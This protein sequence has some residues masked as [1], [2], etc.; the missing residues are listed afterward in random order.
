[1]SAL[2]KSHQLALPCLV[3]LSAGLMIS[4]C[5]G[6]PIP[7]VPQLHVSF[8]VASGGNS[9]KSMAVP[10]ESAGLLVAIVAN[11]SDSHQPQLFSGQQKVLAKVLGFDPISRLQF[12]Q[13]K[14]EISQP[15]SAWLPEVDGHANSHL[16]AQTLTG[17]VQC[18]TLGWTKLIGGKVLPL[19]LLRVAFD[20]EVPLPGTP[21]VTKGGGIVAIVF[22]ASATGKEAYAIPAEAVHR[23]RRD[24]CEGR[25]LIRGWLG[26]ALRAENQ[27]PQVVRVLPDSPAARAGTLPGDVL[28]HIGKRKISD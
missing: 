1:M 11:G 15:V 22:Q 26:L 25:P 21:L 14:N 3:G 28:T 16:T 20:G 8:Q 27:I 18:R 19:A 13:I 4:V 24:L 5:C 7:A 23:V 12:L 17:P 2:V 10:V 6:Q 9:A